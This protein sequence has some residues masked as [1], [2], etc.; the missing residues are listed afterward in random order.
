[1][2]QLVQQMDM[3]EETERKSSIAHASYNYINSILGSGVIGMP[4]A[5]HQAG[6]FAGLGLMALVAVITDYSLLIMVRAGHLAG[7]F[8]YQGMME[9]AFGRPGFYILSVIQ[10]MYPVIAMISYNII[11][12]D[13]LTKVL[14]YFSSA[15]EENT[16]E[17]EFQRESVVLLATLFCT[18]P[19]S[20]YRN[21]ANLSKVSF[22]S[23]VSIAIILLAI[24]V[25]L[26]T[27]HIPPT[28]DAWSFIKP[29]GVISA[30]GVFAFAFMCHH[31]TF[32]LY[33]SLKNSTEAKWGTVTHISVGS[34]FLVSVV[35]SMV[36]YATFTGQV[37]GD[38]LENYC[39]NDDLINLARTLFCLTILLTFPLECFVA[40]DVIENVFFSGKQPPTATRHFGIT[41]LIVLLCYVISISTDCLGVV[42]ELNGI[43]AAMPLAYILPA[44]CYIRL[45]P[46]PFL[47]KHKLPA[48]A[49]AIFGTLVSITGLI[50]LLV[51]GPST[52]H[53]S[54]GQQ[55]A[56]CTK[57]PSL[58]SSIQAAAL[59]GVRSS[60]L[61]SLPSPIQ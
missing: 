20:L 41:L 48:I 37:Q 25:R 5:L 21:V 49:T 8:T 42:L 19:L 2:S 11:V 7:S 35:F 26:G 9:S 30:I 60:M 43:L 32:M 16:D 36:G 24:I 59:T 55:M 1:M 14:I 12:G 31:N 50:I 45:D 6:L 56:Y 52:E 15:K 51:N 38:L 44:L 18:L 27:M 17:L 22:L 53:C 34:S 39:W 47:S 33:G 4:Y 23:L 29:G 61:E 58:N 13:T 40:R 10:F 3:D 28:P 46:S 57:G 54:H